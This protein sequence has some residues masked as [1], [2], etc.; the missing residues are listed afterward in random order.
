MA[1]SRR[2]G[3]PRESQIWPGFVDAMTALLLV[4]MFVLTIFLVVQSVLRDTITSQ[5]SELDRLSDEMTVLSERLGLEQRRGAELTGQLS[6]AQ[7][8]AQRQ[9]QLAATLTGQLDDATSRIAT[10]E[11]QVASLIAAR[12]D[13]QAQNADLS[14]ARDEALSREEQLTLALAT[15][16]SEVDAQAEQARLAAAR[17]EAIEAMVADL[18]ARAVASE[19]AATAAQAALTEAEQQQIVDS[20]AAEALRARLQDGQ[21]ELTAMSLNLEEQRRKAEETLTLLAA[22]QASATQT[23]DERATALATAEAVLASERVKATEAEKQTAALNAQVAEL[24]AQLSALQ[25]TLNVQ[26]AT[27]DAQ[28]A[29]I[30]DLGGKLNVALARAAEEQRRRAELEEA[31][32]KRLASEAEQLARYRSEFFGQLSQILQGREGVRIVGDRFV[33]S[34]EVLFNVGS[35]DLSD[36]G[37]A[38][39]ADVAVGLRDIAAQIPDGLDWILRVDGFTD[40]LPLS[41]TGQFRDNWELSQ[42]RALSVVRFLQDSLGFPPEH[43]AATGFGQ[44][45]PVAE[46]DTADARAQNRRIELKLT[47]R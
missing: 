35:A 37:R 45:Q 43:L 30:D 16:R 13:L 46:G 19:Q 21:A 23:A 38:Q 39:I 29:Q 31:E 5:G 4:L 26:D 11:D 20:A 3:R 1:L 17:R 22:A 33:F 15:A 24:R 14:K 36:E 41:G 47:E 28:Q 7:S 9:A 6:D 8:E 44:Y 40:N 32:R 12:T 34:S 18:Q 25:Q 42:A 10:F 27:G 2:G